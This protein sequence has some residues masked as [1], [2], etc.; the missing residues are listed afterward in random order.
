MFIIIRDTRERVGYWEF[1]EAVCDGLIE[2]TLKTG[3]YSIDG[4]EDKICIER[5]K[6]VS[7]LALNVTSDAFQREIIRIEQYPHRFLILEFGID[8]I[9]QYPIGSNIPKKAWDKVKVKG[10]YILKVLSDIQVNRGIHVIYAGSKNNAIQ[11]AATLM[12]RVYAKYKEIY[13]R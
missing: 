1:S 2:R 4:M 10:R 6:S 13:K 12:H 3:D 7:E 9:K 5:K 8:D 11:I